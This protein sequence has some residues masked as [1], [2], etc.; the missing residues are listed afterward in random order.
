MKERNH[1]REILQLELA[2]GKIK[3]F[4]NHFVSYNTKFLGTSINDNFY[5]DGH[6]TKHAEMS[7][8]ICFGYD[9][10]HNQLHLLQ[11]YQLANNKKFATTEI[12]MGLYSYW[13]I[14]N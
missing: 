5:I 13:E 11:V 2:V 10:V 6:N 3:N 12:S 14:I 1:E 8:E 9:D 4:G 7:D